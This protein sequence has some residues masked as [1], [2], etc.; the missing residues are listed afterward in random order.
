MRFLVDQDVY[1]TTIKWLRESG[2]D[3]VTAKELGLHQ[4]KDTQLLRKASELDRGILTRDKD[5]GMLV[6]LEQRL[7]KGVI[8]LSIDP[9]TVEAVHNEI[10]K[11]IKGRNEERFKNLFCIVEPNRHRIRKL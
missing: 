8:R 7:S 10:D 2:H 11:L 5:F 6:F 1:Q 4:A 3:V 9:T